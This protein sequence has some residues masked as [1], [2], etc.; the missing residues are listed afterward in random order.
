MLIT[1]ITDF[2]YKDPFSGIM[3]GVILSINPSALIVD[4]THGINPHDVREAAFVVAETYRYFP[5]KS[6]HMV[7]VDPGVG[8]GR[9]PILVQADDYYFIGPDN[10]VFTAIFNSSCETLKVIHLTSEHYFLQRKGATFHGRDVFAPVSA[11][12]S[13][14][15]SISNFGE[16][17]TDYITIEL[18]LPFTTDDAVNGEVIFIDYF[19]NAI[20]NIK[21]HEIDTLFSTN[22][23][24]RLE[25]QIKGAKGLL[26]NYY[27]EGNEG[28]GGVINSS[29]YLEL[30]VY[31]GSVRERFNIN[32]GDPVSVKVV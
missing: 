32:V 21:Q 3:K 29:G 6:I 23:K 25:I 7:V 27:A 24:G 16:T 26:R 17:I 4:V 2:G 22:P 19:G 9:R 8:G 10:G 18:P 12:L 13:R 15:I 31:M 28:L 14:G 5:P 20:T 30:F 11:W 1:L